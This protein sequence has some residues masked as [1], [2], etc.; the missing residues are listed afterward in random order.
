MSR[1]SPDA[2]ADIKPTED[3]LFVPLRS[4]EVFNNPNRGTG[5]ESLGTVEDL[6]NELL[7]L[8]ERVSTLEGELDTVRDEL[9]W[10]QHNLTM[11]RD[12]ALEDLE[13]ARRKLAEVEG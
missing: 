7:E 9:W 12:A 10:A 2:H 3:F 4:I 8:R 13:E 11:E 6:V 5:F 1:L